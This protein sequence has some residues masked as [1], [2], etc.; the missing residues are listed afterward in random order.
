MENKEKEINAL[1]E[2][3]VEAVSGGTLTGVPAKKILTTMT[4]DMLEKA[5]R[6]VVKYGGP[7]MYRKPNRQEIIR[8]MLSNPSL[9]LTPE[10]REK[11]QKELEDAVNANDTSKS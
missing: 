10:Q 2:K 9:N 7:S 4:P 11:F 6:L 3:D 1:N 8:G 5:K